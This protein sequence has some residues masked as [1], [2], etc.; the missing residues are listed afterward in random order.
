MGIVAFNLYIPKMAGATRNFP[1]IATMKIFKWRGQVL[2][3]LQSGLV[4]REREVDRANL[5]L[6]SIT[7]RQISLVIHGLSMELAK[8][9]LKPAYVFSD[10]CIHFFEGNGSGRS[11]ATG[12]CFQLELDCWLSGEILKARMSLIRVA[13]TISAHSS[14][15]ADQRTG[16][17]HYGGNVCGN[18]RARPHVLEIAL[19]VPGLA[20]FIGF[21]LPDLV[22][23]NANSNRGGCFLLIHVWL[24]GS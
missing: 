21:R 9:V 13:D 16:V 24:F 15:V 1:C 20:C 12:M 5:S 17:A 2:F 6:D 7:F 8:P 22:S 3:Q 4:V 19:P 18:G 23:S 10:S 11:Y 14:H